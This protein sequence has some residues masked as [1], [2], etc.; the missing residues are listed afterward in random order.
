MNIKHINENI[1]QEY[2]LLGF[3]IGGG[4][5][6]FP[7]KELVFNKPT[8]TTSVCTSLPVYP[9]QYFLLDK[10]RLMV[11]VQHF[12]VFSE[13][14][15]YLMGLHEYGFHRFTFD[16]ETYCRSIESSE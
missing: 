7:D 3:L 12:Q 14:S 8:S 1:H 15:S 5:E 16:S 9:F 2:C 13:L 4:G 11:Y 6:N 10:K